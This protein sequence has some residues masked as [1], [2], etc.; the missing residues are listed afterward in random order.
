[1][2]SATYLSVELFLENI[3][4]TAKRAFGKKTQVLG[5]GHSVQ[6]AFHIS[7]LLGDAS[8]ALQNNYIT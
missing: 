1:M 2:A 8:R 7:K 4:Q 6:F 3:F 5:R